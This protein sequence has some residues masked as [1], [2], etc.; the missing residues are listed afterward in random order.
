MYIYIHN[1]LDVSQYRHRSYKQLRKIQWLYNNQIERLSGNFVR[2]DSQERIGRVTI[3][4][5]AYRRSIN[6][7]CGI[8]V[9]FALKTVHICFLLYYHSLNAELMIEALKSDVA[10]IRTNAVRRKCT[11]LNERQVTYSSAIQIFKLLT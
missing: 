1:D 9:F 6:L 8:Q 11:G 7:K 4:I 5:P 10:I 3:P 2:W